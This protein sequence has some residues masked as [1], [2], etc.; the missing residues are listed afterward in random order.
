MTIAI[1]WSTLLTAI[2][3][4]MALPAFGGQWLDGRWGTSPVFVAIGAALGFL[5]GMLHLLQIAKTGAKK[6]S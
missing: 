1:E 3:L 4:E 6:R 5:V 2:G